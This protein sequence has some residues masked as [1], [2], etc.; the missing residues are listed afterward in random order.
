MSQRFDLL[1]P[2][3]GSD[4]KT[5][6]SNLGSMWQNDQGKFSLTFNALPIPAINK[7]SGAIEVRVIGKV[8]EP[9]SNGQQ[10]S[11]GHRPPQQ[12]NDVPFPGDSAGWE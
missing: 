5:Y 12:D 6:W 8:P 4:G 1:Q 7:K 11:Y 2:R 9:K 10:P 3:E